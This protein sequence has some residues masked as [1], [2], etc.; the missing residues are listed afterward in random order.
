MIFNAARTRAH[1]STTEVIHPYRQTKTQQQTMHKVSQP[2]HVTKSPR[3]IKKILECVSSPRQISTDNLSSTHSDHTG[4][5]TTHNAR[6]TRRTSRKTHSSKRRAV[7]VQCTLPTDTRA[8]DTLF[9][10]TKLHFTPTRGDR[11]GSSTKTPNGRVRSLYFRLSPFTPPP[12]FPLLLYHP[13]S[14]RRAEKV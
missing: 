2:L 1:P 14:A 3:S 5:L 9:S 13:L 8:P 7:H 4:D 12:P 6:Q 10:I 11:Q